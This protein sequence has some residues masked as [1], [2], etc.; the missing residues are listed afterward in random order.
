MK[1]RLIAVFAL[2]MLCAPAFAQA[3][4]QPFYG[5]TTS[6]GAKG[7]QPVDTTHGLPMGA[8]AVAT[9]GGQSLT[10]GVQYPIT[11]DLTGTLCTA[12]GGGGSTSVTQGTVPWVVSGQGTAGVP[13]TGVVTVQGITSGT[14]V[15][16]GVTGGSVGLLGSSASIG[17]VIVDPTTSGGLSTYFVQPAASDN[18][19]VI[20]NGAG[21]RE[22]STVV[23]RRNRI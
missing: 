8:R 17:R 18:H 4:T 22:L 13:A 7:F 11:Q 6:G 20:K 10:A 1:L 21:D 14:S 23:R 9:C 3:P 16:V 5:V 15:N 19:V 2:S 12:S